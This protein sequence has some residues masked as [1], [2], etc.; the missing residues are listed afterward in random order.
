[1]PQNPTNQPIN[2]Q[3]S[4]FVEVEKL[5]SIMDYA[6]DWNLTIKWYKYKPE[7]VLESEMQNYLGFWNAKGLLYPSQ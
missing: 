1:M 3:I 5:W 6:K 2:H 4:L 7:S